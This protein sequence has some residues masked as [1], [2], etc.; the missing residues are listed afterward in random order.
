MWDVVGGHVSNCGGEISCDFESKGV[1]LLQITQ[2]HL[3]HEGDITSVIHV[4]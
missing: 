2:F 4:R 3:G 1:A